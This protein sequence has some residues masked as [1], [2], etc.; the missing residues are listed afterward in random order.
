MAQFLIHWEWNNPLGTLEMDLQTLIV[1]SLGSKTFWQNT[2][3]SCCSLATKDHLPWINIWLIGKLPIFWLQHV[4]TW[5]WVFNQWQLVG[6]TTP[7]GWTKGWPFWPS[8][9][10]FWGSP[11]GVVDSPSRDISG[12]QGSSNL[13]VWPTTHHQPWLRPNPPGHFPN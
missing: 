8:K 5:F 6:W 7:S 1:T 3:V 4:G 13:K 10:T 2:A 11:S 12:P 9:I